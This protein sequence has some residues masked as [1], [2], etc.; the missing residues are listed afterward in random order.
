MQQ[1]CVCVCVP[2]EQSKP[3]RA[4]EIEDRLECCYCRDWCVFTL[5]TKVGDDCIFNKVV[6][7]VQNGFFSVAEGKEILNR[8]EGWGSF[9]ESVCG[10]SSSK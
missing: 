6:D 7:A 2:P 9:R 8:P 5:S 10:A 1:R 3:I 4:Y